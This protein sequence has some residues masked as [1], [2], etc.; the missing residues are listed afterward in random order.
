MSV[1]QKDSAGEISTFY[2]YFNQSLN[3]SEIST[4]HLSVELAF[5]QTVVKKYY[6]LVTNVKVLGCSVPKYYVKRM[7]ENYGYCK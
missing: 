3:S 7:L 4:G 6:V 2:N 5:W 1:C